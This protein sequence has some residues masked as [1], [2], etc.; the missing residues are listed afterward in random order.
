MDFVV[1]RTE[2]KLRGVD[3]ILAFETASNYMF[4]C[5]PTFQ[6]PAYYVYAIHELDINGVECTSINS[7]DDIK[8]EQDTKGVRYTT[9]E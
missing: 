2:N 6:R 4:W 8:W 1:Q 9:Q 7:L 3:Y 5:S